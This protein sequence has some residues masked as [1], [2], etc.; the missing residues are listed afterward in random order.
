MEQFLQIDERIVR[1]TYT[2][3]TPV[4]NTSLFI[5]PQWM[6]GQRIDRCPIDVKDV[7][8]IPREIYKS[9][10]DGD[11]IVKVIQTVDGQRTF[12]ENL[13][14]EYDRRGWRVTLTIAFEPEEHIYGLGQDEDGVLD[15]R[16]H[17][18]YLYQHN[19]KTPMP[20]FVSSKGYAVLFNCACLMVFDDTADLCR[21]TLECVDQLDFYVI[22]GTM[23]QIIAGYR[24]LTG[25]ATK[26]PDWVLGYWQSK[27]KYTSQQELVD[28]AI[29]HRDLGI[30]LDVIVQ[31]W[32]TWVGDL[33]GDKH[34]DRGRYPNLK[35]AT[36]QLKDI[37]VHSIVSVWPNMNAGGKDHQEFAQ[38]GMLLN[39]FSTYDAFDPKARAVYWKQ[40]EE[41]LYS[42]GFDGW[43]CD[44]TEPF[45]SPDWCGEIKLPEEKRYALVGGEHEKYLDPSVANAYALVH[46][47]GIFENQ[48]EKPV[49]NLTRSGWAGI[50]K[51]GVILWAGDASA[52]WA[53]LK[54]EIA[55][56][57]NI[58]LCGIPYWT[59]DAGAFF[60]G[61]TKC[62]RKW[63]EDP[64]A[65]PVWFWAGDYD[66]GVADK[67]YQ[68]LYTRWL[69]FA[70]FLPIFRSHGTDTP[71]EVWNF[72][73]PFRSAI[74]RTIRLRYR[75]MP[76]I[77]EMFR[78]V[79]EEHFT[80]IRSLLFDFPE[81]PM[82][83][84]I[85]DEF[86]FGT[87]LLICPVTQPQLYTA[88]SK[89]I[90]PENPG[91]KCYLPAGADW[92][93]FHTGAFHR[94]GQ[95][96]FVPTDLNTIPVFVRAGAAIPVTEGRMYAEQK[97]PVTVLTYSR[98]PEI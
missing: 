2:N 66:D 31:D 14:T 85:D 16:G 53:E 5:D 27:E 52:T 19:M 56:G 17:I 24:R 48:P 7:T 34:L 64:T 91:R 65:A 36:D 59:V 96:V 95:T 78:K 54:R 25:T 26:M 77:R 18:E 33:W 6:Q 35:S 55:K 63:K 37:N 30:P 9:R 45:T 87:D 13:K 84:R 29:R 94:G 60:T 71:R 83:A 89:P 98:Q 43:W 58:S 57:L 67:G 47:Q 62:W 68:E 76:Y 97:T 21:I 8:F 74:L 70:C 51:Y 81:D 88:G 80:I 28:V 41:E 92:Y 32:K 49:I 1:C 39:D 23:D 82:A 4:Q 69:Q 72:Q 61:S 50:Q 15:K 3:G 46:A 75:L 42:G 86:M 93:D 40:S 79:H 38:K 12:I 73:E 20:M 10:P 11:P 90:H 44:S 22:R